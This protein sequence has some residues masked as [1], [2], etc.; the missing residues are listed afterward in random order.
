MSG[1]LE[2]LLF[3]ELGITIAAAAL[4]IWRSFLDMKEDDHLTLTQAEEHLDREQAVIRKKVKTL[5]KYIHVVGVVWAVL[6]VVVA[7]VFVVQGLALI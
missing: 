2:N 7:G 3:V 6:A 5:T 4:F 1:T